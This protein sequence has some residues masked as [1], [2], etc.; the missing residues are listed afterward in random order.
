MV[1]SCSHLMLPSLHASYVFYPF[2]LFTRVPGLPVLLSYRSRLCLAW[3][4]SSLVANY[5]PTILCNA[6]YNKKKEKMKRKTLFY[7]VG[8]KIY[9]GVPDMCDSI[10]IWGQ[11]LP[12]LHD[13]ITWIALWGMWDSEKPTASPKSLF[14][15]LRSGVSILHRGEP[16]QGPPESKIDRSLGKFYK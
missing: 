10:G 5:T 1:V 6:H 13:G 3:V 2:F 15:F 7:E 14:L 8:L 12:V 4:A 11:S 16:D 9:L